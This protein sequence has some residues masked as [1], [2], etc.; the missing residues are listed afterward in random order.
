MKRGASGTS[1]VVGVDKPAG[2]TSHDVVGKVRRIFGEK[3]VG[4][5]GTLDPLATGVLP[6]LIGPATRLDPYLSSEGKTYVAG[7]SFGY[8]TDTDDS[9]G[10]IVARA[11]TPSYLQDEAY[12]EKLLSSMVGARMQIPPVYSAIKVNGKKACD[13]AR[14][15]NVM[16]L[17]ARRINIFDARLQDIYE[18]DRGNIAWAVRF[19]V[20]K[21]T[22]IRSLARDI[23]TSAGTLAYISSLR[24]ISSGNLHID[25]CVSLETLEDIGESAALDIVKLLGY[26]FAFLDDEAAKKVDNGAALPTEALK[27]YEYR[28]RSMVD[29]CCCTSAIME[30]DEPPFGSELVSLIAENRLQ[31]IY[32]FDD[33]A[34]LFASACN[35]QIGVLRGSYC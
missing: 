17:E 35:F 15:G 14:K 24:R 23:G 8:S 32:K 13:E 7:I 19:H 1:L 34:G 6:I 30:N 25:D 3:R 2:M 12:A 16:H 33:A 31:A 4:H 18:D 20:S 9:L 10:D 29:A 26:R 11:D 22:Y 27:L 28:Y 5:A 21:G